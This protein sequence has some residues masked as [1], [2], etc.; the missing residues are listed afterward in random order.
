[1]PVPACDGW[2]DGATFAILANSN[3]DSEAQTSARS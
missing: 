2:G 1:M 3:L